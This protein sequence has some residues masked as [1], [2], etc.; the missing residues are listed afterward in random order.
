MRAVH[1]LSGRRRGPCPQHQHP[2]RLETA[3]TAGK[4]DGEGR[5]EQERGRE[6]QV[7]FSSSV[8]RVACLGAQVPRCL[9]ASVPQC[10]LACG[11]RTRLSKTVRKAGDPRRVRPSTET[12]GLRT[13][14]SRFLRHL[15]LLFQQPAP[16]SVPQSSGPHQR[17]AT[18]PNWTSVQATPVPVPVDPGCR[19]QVQ[20]TAYFLRP[21]TPY[22]TTVRTTKDSLQS[23]L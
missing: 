2:R 20:P 11:V 8:L 7:K 5:K 22:C 3:L 1:T 10:L 14:G 21:S 23:R 9:S 6:Q 15:R 19:L 4:K 18:G 16:S 13:T 12:A 17:I